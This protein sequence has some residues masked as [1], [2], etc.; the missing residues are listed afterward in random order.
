MGLLSFFK[1]VGEKITY[2]T[3]LPAEFKAILSPFVGAAAA[4][5]DPQF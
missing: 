2:Y 4:A 1:G 3:Q 5:A